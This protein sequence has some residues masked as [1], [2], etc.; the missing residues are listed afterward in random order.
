MY[1]TS[2]AE[3]FADGAVKILNSLKVVDYL[4]FGAETSDMDL[5]EPIADVLYKEPKAYKML[6]A[7]ELKK[8]FLS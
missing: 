6:L 5:L 4:A 2:S 7:N 1:A 8:V 3:N